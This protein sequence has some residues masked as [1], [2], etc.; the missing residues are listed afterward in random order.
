MKIDETLYNEYA[1]FKIE[2]KEFLENLKTEAYDIYYIFRDVL[3]V[4]EFLYNSLVDDNDY[5]EELD[6]MFKTGYLHLLNIIIDL[7]TLFEDVYNENYKLMND[8]ASDINLLLNTYEFQREVLEFEGEKS[9]LAKELLEIDKIIYNK[10]S[11]KEQIEDSIYERL[12][13]LV[14]IVFS[15]LNI[16]Y[17]SINN[18]FLE[19]SEQLKLI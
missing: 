6:I 14:S 8:F 5:G 4:I 15:E 19:I 10:L 12:N 2:N 16:D 17:I 18:I 7:K 1:N 11:K 13:Y 3:E 9:S